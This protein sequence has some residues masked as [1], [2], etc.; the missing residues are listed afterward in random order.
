[1]EVVIPAALDTYHRDHVDWLVQAMKVANE[2][3]APET[4]TLALS[5]DKDV[6]Q[7]GSNRPFFEW[8]WR[9]VDAHQFLNYYFPELW[10]NVV[11]M[12]VDEFIVNAGANGELVIVSEEHRLRYIDSPHKDNIVFVP[13]F[14]RIHST[15]IKDKLLTAMAWSNCK[16]RKVSAALVKKGYGIVNMTNNGP[17]LL[18][19][20]NKC[21]K[22]LDIMNCFELTGAMK[23]STTPCAYLHAEKSVLHDFKAGSAEWLFTTT[24][25][26]ADCAEEIAKASIKG[27]ERVVFFDAYHDSEPIKQLVNGNYVSIRRAGIGKSLHTSFSPEYYQNEVAVIKENVLYLAQRNNVDFS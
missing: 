15:S 13:P 19:G 14:D 8:S 23:P 2:Y 4:I 20:C 1:M 27:L 18:D 17:E 3:G 26:C 6:S 5:S 24:A 10:P 11:E 7:K 9:Y 21:P 25:P 12:N 16:I 22:Y